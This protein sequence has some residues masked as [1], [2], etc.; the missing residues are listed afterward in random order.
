M[1]EIMRERDRFRQVLVEPQSARDAARDRSDFHGVSQARAQMIA[2]AIEE[3]LRFVFETAERARMDH[4]VAIPL[5]LGAPVGRGFF[6]FA[7]AG[8]GAE[9]SVR[10]KSLSLESFEF[11][12]GARHGLI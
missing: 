12:A 4:A 6:I 2:G 8:I 3:H 5:I 10:G 7:A 9:L 1:A 11:D